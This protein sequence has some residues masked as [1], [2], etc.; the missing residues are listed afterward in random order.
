MRKRSVL[1]MATALLAL[2][3]CDSG[4][5]V[6]AKNES[7][8]SVR[9]KVANAV[10]AG[11]QMKPG[12]WTGTISY[13]A[14]D[15]P[16]IEKMPPEMQARMKAELSK[17]RSFENCLTPEDLRDPK[18]RIAG[19]TGGKCTY[20]NF[21][22]AGGVIDAKMTCDTEAG[23]RVMT[24]K[25]RYSGDTYDLQVVSNGDGTEMAAAPTKM[26]LSAKRTGACKADKAD[27]AGKA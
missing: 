9:Q 5:G 8:E 19:N 2:N 10:G 17:P 22:M 23:R 3:A 4:K 14:T 12:N 6:S 25:G 18:A 11:E 7:V 24:M 13:A 27:K 1:V 20:D 21:T 15:I 26:T 16:G